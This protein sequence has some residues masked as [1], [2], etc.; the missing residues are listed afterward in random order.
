MRYR[1]AL[2]L[3]DS[4]TRQLE[5]TAEAH[6]VSK[7]AIL[8]RALL[9]FLT[10][11]GTSPPSALCRLQ[12]DAHA[13]SL[14]RLERDLAVT[15][16]LLATLTR[17]FLMITPP[18]PE[19]EQRAA[20]TL[21]RLRFDQVVEDVARRLRT[22]RSLTAQVMSRLDGTGQKS[23]SDNLGRSTDHAAATSQSV[24]GAPAQSDGDG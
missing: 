2:Y 9:S 12:Q 4:L 15:T 3:S 13:R 21:G 24:P 23:A 6:R 5:L 22:D 19:A 17:Y 8:E 14:S 1:H 10:P 20:T 16:E 7:S 11:N 18:L